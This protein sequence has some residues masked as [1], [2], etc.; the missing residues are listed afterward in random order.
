MGHNRSSTDFL[1]KLLIAI[2]ILFDS[3]HMAMEDKL[4]LPAFSRLSLKE[5]MKT[6]NST[7][8]A[9]ENPSVKIIHVVAQKQINHDQTL[10]CL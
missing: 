4:A 8:R 1:N 2:I 6:G 3:I 7:P 10:S 9:K 5:S